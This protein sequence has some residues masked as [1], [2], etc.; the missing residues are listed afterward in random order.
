MRTPEQISEMIND[1][2]CNLQPRDALQICV[3]T[4]AVQIAL[5]DL[6]PGKTRMG[7][8][9]E[10]LAWTRRIVEQLENRDD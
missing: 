1:L 4:F 3:T 10:L 5:I 9:D 6:L 2:L 7:I 8:A